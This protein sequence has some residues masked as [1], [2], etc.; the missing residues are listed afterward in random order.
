MA[1]AT[2]SGGRKR[3]ATAFISVAHCAAILVS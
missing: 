1:G 3:W 2:P